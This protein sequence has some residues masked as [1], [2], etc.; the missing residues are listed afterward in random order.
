MRADPFARELDQL[1]HFA[2]ASAEYRPAG[3]ALSETAPARSAGAESLPLFPPLPPAAP[4]PVQELG[5]VLS[6]AAQAIARKVQ[7]PDAI[8]AQSVLAAASLAAQ[9]HADVLMPYGQR[10]PL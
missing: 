3:R 9:A 7:A 1:D 5:T 4:Y 6:E 2:D 8:A 10:R